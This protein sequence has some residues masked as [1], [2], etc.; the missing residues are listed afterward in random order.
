[1]LCCSKTNLKLL[2]FFLC[3]LFFLCCHS[4][5]SNAS[6][7][8]KDSV[9]LIK[10]QLPAI[11]AALK[12][13]EAYQNL[14]LEKIA[15]LYLARTSIKNIITIERYDDVFS[16][17]R[18]WTPTELRSQE[19]L[20][21]QSFYGYL[22]SAL[23]KISF[24][25]QYTVH[26]DILQ[27]YIDDDNFKKNILFG[28]SQ[29]IHKDN[30]L[31]TRADIHQKTKEIFIPIYTDEPQHYF[32]TIDDYYKN[33]QYRILLYK[34]V[35][36]T[37]SNNKYVIPTFRKEIDSE[38]V[39]SP[40]LKITTKRRINHSSTSGHLKI[41]SNQPQGPQEFYFVDTSEK[42]Y[43][44]VIEIFS[45]LENLNF[46]YGAFFNIQAFHGWPTLLRF[47]NTTLDTSLGIHHFPGEQRKNIKIRDILTM[48]PEQRNKH[49]PEFFFIAY[50]AQKT[51]G[52]ILSKSKLHLPFPDFS[53]IP[54]KI[55][56]S[57]I[58]ENKIINKFIE[59]ADSSES[60]EGLIEK[61]EHENIFTDIEI[62]NAFKALASSWM[63]VI[64]P[65]EPVQQY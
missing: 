29:S 28:F 43:M 24:V 10:N 45:I 33:S 20:I 4:S 9:E 44:S 63:N 59:L 17:K 21:Y 39:N 14:P 11:D 5:L 34:T 27:Q 12:K 57:L 19:N 51:R 62:K 54:L 16:R 48:N 1:M 64:H 40:N 7:D 22:N 23:F 3:H 65:A 41:R 37:E 13:Q 6:E 31:E 42:E 61:I 53:K 50:L 25:I 52:N 36:K 18:I 35:P 30:V 60:A 26:A 46:E 2:V 15:A 32:K 55:Q 38:I 8:I 58:Q 47:E 56:L 49:F